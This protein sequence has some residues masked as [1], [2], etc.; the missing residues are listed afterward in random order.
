MNPTHKETLRKT[1]PDY[2]HHFESPRSKGWHRK[3]VAQ[4]QRAAIALQYVTGW[5]VAV[6]VGA[7]C[8]AWSY[9][10]SQRFK[11]VHTFE[12][13]PVNFEYVQKNLAVYKNVHLH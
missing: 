11:T 9:A 7:Y 10:F 3:E 13:S 1:F 5:H 6:D 4:Y 12:A 2:P 8:G